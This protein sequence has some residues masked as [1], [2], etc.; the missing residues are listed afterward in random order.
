[1]YSPEPFAVTDQAEIND[2]LR[3][4]PFGSLI[5]HGPN[6]LFASQLPLLHDPDHQILAGHLA[7]TNPHPS[8]AG[9]G[10]ALVIFQ[11]ANA[12]VTPNWYP[13]KTE[14]GRV[15]PT[16]NYEVAHVYGHISWREDADWLHANVTALTER[17]EAHQPRPW[18][19]DDAPAEYIGRLIGGIIGVEF[20]IERIEAKRKLSQ[21]RVEADRQGV[22]AGLSQSASAQDNAV[23]KAMQALDH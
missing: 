4:T 3:R 23:A 22:V 19:V 2:L 16:W 12:Y 20:R 8:L 5:T 10:E 7:R 18:A 17:F 21:N 1:M 13:T 11:G 14:H 6:G 9:D 15:V